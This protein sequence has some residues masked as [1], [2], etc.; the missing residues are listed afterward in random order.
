MAEKIQY[1]IIQAADGKWL[2]RCKLLGLEPHTVAA[3][4]TKD[5]AL[6][7]LDSLRGSA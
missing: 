7:M 1:W 6:E 2:V 5:E 3:F 4:V